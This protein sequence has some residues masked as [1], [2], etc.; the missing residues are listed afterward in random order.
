M[1]QPKFHDELKRLMKE[2]V[3]GVYDIT[4]KFPKSEIFGSVSQIRRASLSVLLNYTEGFARQRENTMKHFFEIS[5][6]SLKESMVLLEFTNERNYFSKEEFNKLFKIGDQ[7][8]KMLWG[9]LIKIK[10]N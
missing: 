5:Y 10:N 7:I 9:T 8:G 3:H 2:Y 4:E 6:G 1:E